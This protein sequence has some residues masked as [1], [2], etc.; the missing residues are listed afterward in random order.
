MEQL[1]VDLGARS[2][3]ILI[4]DGLIR[5]I[6]PHVAPLLKRPRT[7]IVTDAHVAEHYLVPLGTALAMENISFSSFVL[8]PGEATKS[9]AGLARLA[10]WLIGEG[11]E[12]SDHVVALGGGDDAGLC[13]Y[14]MGDCLVPR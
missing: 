2:Y 11:I 4:G 9:W 5:N 7:M 6:G 3:P 8:E 14:A 12:R 10:E 13:R 1:T